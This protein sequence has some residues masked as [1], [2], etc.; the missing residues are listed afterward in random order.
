MESKI[1]K[2]IYKEKNFIPGL[3]IDKSSNISI[4]K[5]KEIKITN[6]I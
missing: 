6:P 2:T 3:N 5:E 4:P 1:R